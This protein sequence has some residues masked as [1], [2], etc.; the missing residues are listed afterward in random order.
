VATC[1]QVIQDLRPFDLAD[2]GQ[3]FQL[4]NNLF[5]ANKIGSIK[6]PSVF[7]LYK[8]LALRIV[9]WP[10]NIREAPTQKICVICVICGYV[11]SAEL[12]FR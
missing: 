7:C 11:Q 5:V 6:G 8:T 9:G 3:S 2:F 4:E 12:A 1:F 10:P